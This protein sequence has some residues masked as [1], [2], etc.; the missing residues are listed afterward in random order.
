MRPYDGSMIELPARPEPAEAEAVLVRDLA[1]GEA[2]ARTVAPILRHLLATDDGA[3]FGEEVIARVRAMTADVAT[4]LLDAGSDAP[5]VH[6]AEAVAEVTG[7]LVD[8]PGFLVHLHSLAVEWQV[9]ERLQVRVALDP[10]L[11]PIAHAL[12]ASPDPETAGLAM[13][14]L[15]SQARFTQ[16][17][18]RMRLPLAELPADVL[19]EVLLAFGGAGQNDPGVAAIRAGYDEARSRLG[20]LSRLVAGMGPGVVAALSIEHAGVAMFLSAL[21]QVSGDA[22]ERIVLALG[23]ENGTRLALQLRAAGLK[24]A[25]IEAQFVALQAGREAPEAIALLSPDRAAAILASGMA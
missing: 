19:H 1:E 10:V 6:P 23:E 9:T 22:R 14:L 3:L 7:A 5:T 17:Q 18:R 15:A 13:N 24:P 16:A 12:M 25:A 21:A 11:P 8:A 2:A 20:L 4:R